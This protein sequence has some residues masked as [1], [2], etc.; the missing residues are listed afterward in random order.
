MEELL[1]E[2]VQQDE[3]QVSCETFDNFAMANAITHFHCIICLL[4]SLCVC[5][6]GEMLLFHNILFKP[7]WP[8]QPRW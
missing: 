1:N 4:P 8:V 5:Q 2:T 7:V 3:L 6:Y